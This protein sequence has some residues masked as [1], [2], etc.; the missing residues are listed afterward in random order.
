MNSGLVTITIAGLVAGLVIT[1]T[2][3]PVAAV[4]MVLGVAAVCGVGY[5]CVKKGG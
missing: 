4:C 2:A 5:V 1:I 3:P